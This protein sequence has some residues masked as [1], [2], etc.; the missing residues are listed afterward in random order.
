MVYANWVNSPFFAQNKAT[1]LIYLKS[2]TYPY[3]ENKAFYWLS[4]SYPQLNKTDRDTLIFS[5]LT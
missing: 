4:R 5:S 2:T 1:S 3:I